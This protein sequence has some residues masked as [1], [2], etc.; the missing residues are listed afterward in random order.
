MNINMSGGTSTMQINGM[1]IQIKGRRIFVN[2]VEHEPIGDGGA[3]KSHHTP[4]VTTDTSGN[5][6]ITDGAIVTVEN[7]AGDLTI[8]SNGG[9]D[10]RVSHVGG[11]VN[12][13]GSVRVDGDVHKGV[14]AGGSVRCGNVGAAVSAGD[15]VRC[16]G[17]DGNI[18]AAGSVRHG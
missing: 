8:H 13:D 3:R 9:A 6:T 11:N 12:A 17:V 4:K 18:T 7:V 1:K 2:G 10:I 5:V 15:S 14:A 16:G